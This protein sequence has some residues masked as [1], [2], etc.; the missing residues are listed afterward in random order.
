MGGSV[1]ESNFALNIKNR[2]QS[3]SALYRGAL[4]SD[5][6]PEMSS[7]FHGEERMTE[8]SGKLF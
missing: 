6:A 1:K 8:N 7:L 3:R 4:G 2:A 5:A